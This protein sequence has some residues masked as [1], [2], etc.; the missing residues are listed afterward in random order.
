MPARGIGLER[1]DRGE[2]RLSEPQT[3]APVAFLSPPRVMSSYVFIMS[4]QPLVSSWKGVGAQPCK[5]KLTC[6]EQPQNTAAAQIWALSQTYGSQE[7]ADQ[8]TESLYRRLSTKPARGL[9]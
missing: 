8:N 9:S 1:F 4:R 3:V 2:E 5:W 6:P 7:S